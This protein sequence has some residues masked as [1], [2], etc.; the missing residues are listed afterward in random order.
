M[1]RLRVAATWGVFVFACAGTPEGECRTQP[2]EDAVSIECE[3]QDRW[4][5]EATEEAMEGFEERGPGSR[6]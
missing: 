3:P 4:S 6:P 5:D 1:Q 2:G